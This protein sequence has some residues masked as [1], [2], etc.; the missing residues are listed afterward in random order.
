MKNC[1]P[2][3][4]LSIIIFA[5]CSVQKKFTDAGRMNYCQ[6]MVK[7]ENAKPSIGAN[8][9]EGDIINADHCIKSDTVH[10]KPGTRIKAF[11]T[12]TVHLNDITVYP[13]GIKS[14]K[15]ENPPETD[16]EKIPHRGRW[17][18]IVGPILL[19]IGSF[20][21]IPILIV[22]T[23]PWTGAGYFIA[24]LV[25]LY[26][27]G[28]IIS[29]IGFLGLGDHRDGTQTL[30]ERALESR[31]YLTWGI[32]IGL[33]GVAYTTLSFFIA[34]L[35]L[36]FPIGPAILVI[37]MTILFSTRLNSFERTQLESIHI[38]EKPEKNISTKTSLWLGL[39][40]LNLFVVLCILSTIPAMAIS[41]T[42]V[43]IAAP[44]LL[45]FGLVL[46]LFGLDLKTKKK[47]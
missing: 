8:F 21:V 16:Q 38:P 1:I 15:N 31:K 41:S 13:P 27:A 18:R 14:F 17:A 28:M 40:L 33:T 47:V 37:G 29:F 5:G 4:I 46:L 3:F 44:V 39:L 23:S 9:V 34:E 12:K 7:Q 20:I 42:I 30:V 11:H 32:I 35:A 19:F 45:I 25:L 24:L 10:F 22:L 36:L 2:L 43:W 6:S 26:I